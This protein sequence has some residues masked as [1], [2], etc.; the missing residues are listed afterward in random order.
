[1]TQTINSV[2]ISSIKVMDSKEYASYDV[3]DALTSPFL[4]YLTFKNHFLK[5]VIIQ[6]NS[7]CPINLR[8]V[9]GVKKLVH[10]K[11]ISDLLTIYCL[12]G[13]KKTDF[14]NLNKAKS[15]FDLLI[16]KSINKQDTIA[17]G[18]N[19]PYATRFTD[20]GIDTPNL[21]NTLNS[22]LSILDYYDLTQDYRVENIIDKILDYIFIYLGI[23]ELSDD[24]K[25]VRYYPNQTSPILNVNA[26]AAHFFLRINHTFKK[27]K[28]KHIEIQKIINLLKHFQNFDGSWYYSIND[29]GKWIDGFHTGFILDSLIYIAKNGQIDIG[30]TINKGISY[31]IKNMFSKEGIPK[32]YNDSLYPIESQN[33]AQA[34]QTLA[35]I[36]D[37]LE[38]NIKVKQLLEK[39]I[40]QTIF[41]LYKKELGEFRYK[42][43]RLFKYNQVYFRWSQAPMVLALLKAKNTLSIV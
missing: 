29:K 9:L 6:L 32:Y 42:K 14:N 28:I 40:E 36:T 23:K 18:L 4:F 1:M 39:T 2:I 25:W 22:G 7:K 38:D 26:T 5:R 33:C 24:M 3:Y 27:E 35:K 37:Y 21:Y 8:P 13:A 17:W 43:S 41:F 30:E 16:D 31:Y 20:A 12:L 19:F 34:I 15:M 10:T 11:T